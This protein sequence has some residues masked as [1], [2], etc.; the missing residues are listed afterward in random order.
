[1]S[2]ALPPISARIAE[3]ISVNNRQVEAAIALLDEGATVPF[4]ARYRKEVTGGLDDAQLRTLESRLVYLRELEER[5]SAILKSVEEQDKL[6]PNLKQDILGAETKTRLW[7]QGHR[8][9]S[10]PRSAATA[11]VRVRC[12]NRE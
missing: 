7:H 11:S 1:M 5:R 9:Q 8:R 6:T 4:I 3:E 10:K 12:P 2:T